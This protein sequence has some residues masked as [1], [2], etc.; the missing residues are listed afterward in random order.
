[1][2]TYRLQLAYDGTEFAG[3][4]VQPR[5]RT[6]QGELDRA[7]ASL[8]NDRVKTTF[9]GRTDRGVH[10]IGQVVAA[11][12]A[13]WRE[14]PEDLLRAL[15]TR[16][17]DDLS[18]MAVQNCE[19][20]FHPRFDAIWRE[21]RYRVAFGIADPFTAR[22]AL[23]LRSPLELSVTAGAAERLVGRHDFATFA[24]GGQGVPTSHRFAKRR[25]TTRSIL[26]CEC[27]EVALST[28]AS[29]DAPTRLFEVRV[30]ADGF[31]PQMVRNIV[32]AL[33]EIGQGRRDSDWIDELVAQRDRRV[34]PSP[35]PAR[36]LTLWRVG[37]GND[38][39]YG[40][41]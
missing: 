28:I 4:Q 21:Y 23:V 22:Y 41:Q 3:S 2:P 5:V 9:A 11:S 13:R 33:I 19:P 6:V 24:S 34:G 7:L 17:P 38:A 35:A 32:G 37:F 20:Q 15:G 18:A 10:A 31:L 29:T 39:I 26:R 8:G 36:G 27:R 16:L 14:S 30:V 12:L 25:G 40:W 1:M